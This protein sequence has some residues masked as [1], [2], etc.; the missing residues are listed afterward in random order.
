MVSLL[1]R[2]D[3]PG[4]ILDNCVTA[5]AAA[6]LTGYNIQ[7]IRRLCY[8]GKLDSIHV[9][10]SWLIKVRSL[11]SYLTEV[12][13][14]GDEAAQSAPALADEIKTRFEDQGWGIDLYTTTVKTEEREFLSNQ[15]N[16]VE[17]MLLGLAMLVATVG[18]IGLAGSLSISVMERQREIGVMR[19]IGAHS[20][21]IRWLFILE[22]LLQG[23]LSWLIV[24][25]LSHVISRPLAR[26][27]G[28]TMLEIDL[29]YLYNWPA[30]R[31]GS[32][33]GR[34]FPTGSPVAAKS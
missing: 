6:A 30:R 18:G 7:H 13:A 9:G 2:T 1:L 17:S 23:L 10:R 28:Q 12:V 32:A 26:L 20:R 34:A 24:I 19:A 8:A 27:L 3:H 11:E 31:R 33:C 25:P 22:G 14:E 5:E 4:V 21:T 16:S 29:D 15:F